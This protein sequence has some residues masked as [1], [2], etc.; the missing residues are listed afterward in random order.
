MANK[1]EFKKY[2]EA[3]G[4]ALCDEMMISY[5]NVEGIDKEKVSNAIAKVLGAIGMATSNSNIFFDKGAKA[6]E[7]KKE[8]SK[9][10]KEFFKK[11]FDKINSDFTGTIDE[12]LKE[13]NSA[14]PAAVKEENKK[15]V[16]NG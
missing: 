2:T 8:Y 15:A 1:R 14:I 10:R 16:S 12:A 6:F 7:N 9:A 11:L 13:F 4:A 3:L 5:Y